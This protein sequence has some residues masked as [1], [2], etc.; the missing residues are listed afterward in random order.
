MLTISMKAGVPGA[1]VSRGFS[2]RQYDASPFLLAIVGA[3]VACTPGRPRPTPFGSVATATG[4]RRR[5]GAA[6]IVPGATDSVFID[7]SNAIVSS[8]TLNTNASIRNLTISSGDLL[9]LSDGNNLTFNVGSGG[10]ALANAGTLAL[11]GSY[12][13]VSLI[14]SGGDATLSGA[15]TL[16]MTNYA[17]N[18]I[19]GSASTDRFVNQSTVQGSGNI[20][21]N[22]LGLANSGL[23]VANQSTR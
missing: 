19:T 4:P 12:L 21:N 3:C 22:I 8:V 23:I 13:G 14:V 11:A 16:T 7:N 18:T 15:G 1:S 20:G 6:G 17:G 5:T 9:T 2:P 10:S